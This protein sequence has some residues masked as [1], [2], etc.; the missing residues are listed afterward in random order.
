MLKLL[1]LFLA[2]LDIQYRRFQN[3][4]LIAEYERD[5]ELTNRE[6]AERLDAKRQLQA[7]LM[8]LKAERRALGG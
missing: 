5:L 1:S 7:D 8:H 3:K 2:K 6:I 4:R